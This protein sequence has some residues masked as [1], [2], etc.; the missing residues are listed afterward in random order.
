MTSTTLCPTRPTPT[1]ARSY[2]LQDHVLYFRTCVD[3]GLRTEQNRTEQNRTEQNEA[4]SCKL[5]GVHLLCN[6]VT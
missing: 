5:I 3:M 1:E 4:S 2:G 6:T